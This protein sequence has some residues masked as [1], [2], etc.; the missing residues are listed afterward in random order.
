MVTC[1]RCAEC[2]KMFTPAPSARETQRVCG[3]RCRAVRDRGLARVRRRRDLDDARADERD[4]QRLS[5]QRRAA[6]G[7]HAPPSPRKS[8]LSAKEVRVFVDRALERSRATLARDLGAIL[9]RFG[10]VIGEGPT[11]GSALSRASLDLQG[12][13]K[14]ADSA[15]NL[16]QPSRV[17]L[18]DGAAL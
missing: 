11:V 10:V 9:L 3:A 12:S 8:P 17:S 15:A 13:D 14:K 18:G 4:R 16:A 7:C 6:A 5:R 2:R 1:H